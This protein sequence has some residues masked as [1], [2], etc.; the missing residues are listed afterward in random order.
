MKT[1]AFLAVVMILVTGA[2]FQVQAEEDGIVF[3][4]IYDNYEHH[5]GCRTDWGFSCLVEGFDKTILFDTGTRKEIFAGNAEEMNLDLSRV[6]LVVV[7]HFHGDHTG[8]MDAFFEKKKDV[9]IYVPVDSSEYAGLL[10]ERMRSEGARVIP[11]SDSKEITA[12]VFLTGTMGDAILEQSMILKTGKGLVVLTGC[13]HPGIVAILKKVRKMFPN[14]KMAL[15]FGGFHLMQT[16]DAEIS[17][18]L[19]S[20]KELGVEKLGATHCTGDP[21]IKMFAD[22]YGPNF[23]RLG[24]GRVLK[25]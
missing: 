17:N 9:P 20:F 14:E 6:E 22:A 3:T 5:P 24:V 13:A 15:V 2:F 18:I 19:Q 12:N 23:I 25:F 21:A 4:I 11:V 8:G 10:S 1:S 7:S 16:P